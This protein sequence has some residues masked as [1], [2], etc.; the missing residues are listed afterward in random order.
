MSNLPAIPDNS[1]ERNLRW[2]GM[3]IQF[4]SMYW[5]AYEICDNSIMNEL[6]DISEGKDPPEE[7]TWDIQKQ[8]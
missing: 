8:K 1:L 2:W 6:F 7:Y 3:V 4:G 5:K